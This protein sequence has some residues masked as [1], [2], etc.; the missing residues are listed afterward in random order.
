MAIV[1][2]ILQSELRLTE[3]EPEQL[4]FSRAVTVAGYTHGV[5]E[6]VPQG[7]GSASLE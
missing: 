4:K 2:L 3:Q 5:V 7:L 1:Y 6:T